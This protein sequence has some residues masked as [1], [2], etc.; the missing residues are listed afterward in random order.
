MTTKP[1]PHQECLRLFEKLSE[2][3]DDELDAVTCQ[4]IEQHLKD[5][6]ACTACMQTLKKTVELSKCTGSDPVPETFSENLKNLIR[7][8][9]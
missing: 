2:F 1:Y 6:R 5:C 4:D 3:I 9:S 7:K 8:M